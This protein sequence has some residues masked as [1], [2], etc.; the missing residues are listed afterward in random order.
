MQFD[1]FQLISI[2]HMIHL[3]KPTSIVPTKFRLSWP[4]F[5]AYS[6]PNE[7]THPPISATSL[8]M[9]LVLQKS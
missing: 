4:N 8:T 7:K 5:T 3:Q 2:T 6:V 9:E 1:E